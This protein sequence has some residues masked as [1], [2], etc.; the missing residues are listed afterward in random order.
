MSGYVSFRS[1]E[2][3]LATKLPVVGVVLHEMDKPAQVE[4]AWLIRRTSLWAIPIY[5]TNENPHPLLDG[6]MNL[7]D[8]QHAALYMHNL[9]LSLNL[10]PASLG[11]EE[12]ILVYLYIR[13]GGWLIPEQ[14]ISLLELYHY[15]VAEALVRAR[16]QP[17]EMLADLLRRRLL[18]QRDLIDRTR[19]CPSC[20]SA[21][22]N[23]IDVCP[24]CASI[25]IAM[26]PTLHCFIC[27]Y[28]G[29]EEAFHTQEGLICP[30]CST[31]LRHIGVDYDKP[32]TQYLCKDCGLAFVE[33]D[34]IAR[35]LYCNAKNATTALEVKEFH[36]LG[37]S[38]QGRTALRTG[39]LDESFASLDIPN[40]VVPNYFIRLVDWAMQAQSR[41]PDMGF[42]L[43]ML[44]IVNAEQLFSQIGHQRTFALFDELARRLNELLRDS[45]IITR[46]EETRLWIFLP[47]SST[48]GF[49][50]RLRK[51][52]DEL[53]RTHE[54]GL[55]IRLVGLDAPRDIQAETTAEQIMK[56][57]EGIQD[58]E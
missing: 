44:D 41:H 38:V 33:P 1:V 17:E 34:V 27:G 52:L 16:E 23:Y 40:F 12:R 21:H 37:L 4:A 58:G 25:A 28:V 51:S 7:D 43:V 3:M 14:Q 36:T 31:R 29:P 48:Q 11:L 30:K 50:K 19:H 42:G 47:L 18:Q 2:D 26:T 45:D 49:I 6:Q 56:R 53:M 54:A 5:T 55:E 22:H 20:G 39:R 9:L 32:L 57:L 35:C 13:G 8:A 24:A 15:P 46:T 10:E